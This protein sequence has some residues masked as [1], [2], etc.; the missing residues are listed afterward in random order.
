MHVGS[1]PTST[2]EVLLNYDFY[3]AKA[4][5]DDYAGCHCTISETAEE[6]PLAQTL[7]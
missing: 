4:A 3:L 1:F 5:L 6:T 7:P 2:L